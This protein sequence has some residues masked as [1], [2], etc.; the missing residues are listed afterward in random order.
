VSGQAPA[1]APACADRR[2]TL[3]A[4]CASI[5]ES[6]GALEAPAEALRSLDLEG[7]ETILLMVT[8]S[9]WFVPFSALGTLLAVAC[10]ILAMTWAS[11]LPTVPWSDAQALVLGLSIAGL[12]LS[13]ALLEWTQRLY[14]LTD[15]RVLRR[16]GVLRTF[17]VEEGLGQVRHTVVVASRGE[18]AVGVGTVSFVTAGA[19]GL[20]WTLAWEGVRRP[21][22]VQRIVREAI[23]RYGR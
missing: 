22:E 21:A 18:R 5:G 3:P 8:P 10:G 17:I 15:R 20:D 7:D 11:R 12:R 4:G 1:G 23:D 9:L 16:G 6:A 19:A 2:G 14:L 13:W